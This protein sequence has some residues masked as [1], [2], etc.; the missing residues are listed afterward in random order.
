MSKNIKVEI[1]V[2]G[3][4]GTISE[5][6]MLD[7]SMAMQPQ[8]KSIVSK[9]EKVMLEEALTKHRWNR[10]KVAQILKISYRSI[11]YK[12]KAYGLGSKD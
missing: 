9:I 11:L 8:V 7:T 4:G 5:R 10:G 2:P 1:S 6:I 12:M 3:I